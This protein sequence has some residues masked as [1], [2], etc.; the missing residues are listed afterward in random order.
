MKVKG[1]NKTVHVN[2]IQRK[3]DYIALI[4]D[5]IDL[6]EKQSKET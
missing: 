2:A 1:Q 3:Q 4:S 6:N 5:K